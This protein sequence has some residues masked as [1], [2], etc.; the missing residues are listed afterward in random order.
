MRSAEA[1]RRRILDAAER[2][3]ARHGVEATS[4]RQITAAARVNLAA[5]NYH[6]GAKDALIRE[7]LARRVGPVNQERLARLRACEARTGDQPPS[8]E[9]IVRA[10]VEPVLALRA[11]P[12]A[13]Q[14]FTL[15]MGRSFFEPN[16]QV[17]RV[18]IGQMREVARRFT[19][20]LRRALPHLPETELW[21]RMH[22]S[23]GVLAHTLAGNVH[24]ETLSGGRC[25]TSDLPAVLERLVAF[26]TAGLKAPLPG[27]KQRSGKRKC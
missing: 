12:D 17:R 2:L 19:A 24:L 16:L 5:V 23:A 27:P 21:W 3:F 20:A 6:F 9:E 25:D 11:D 13:G 10:F 4:L 26:V 22:F 15:L 8:V 7:V 18:I 1:T 14:A